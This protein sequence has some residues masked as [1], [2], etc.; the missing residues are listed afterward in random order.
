MTKC[1]CDGDWILYDEATIRVIASTALEKHSY[2]E[3]PLRLAR[4][5]LCVYL[6]ARPTC[7]QPSRGP[8]RRDIALGYPDRAEQIRGRTHSFAQT[9]G[10]R[11]PGP[12]RF[13]LYI[14]GTPHLRFENGLT[15][16]RISNENGDGAA[17]D[18]SRGLGAQVRA[19]IRGREYSL[20][21][22]YRGRLIL[23]TCY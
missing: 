4:P 21:W 17:G 10:L 8:N 11:D 6:Q 18:E 14:K 7:R 22:A 15:E 1:S 20:S 2:A 23:L 19:F 9:E 3:E 12:G 13:S 5:C 16:R